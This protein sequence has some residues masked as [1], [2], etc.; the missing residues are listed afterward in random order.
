MIG[1]LVSKLKQDIIGTVVEN[2]CTN[3][4]TPDKQAF[5]GEFRK[6]YNDVI[7]GDRDTVFGMKVDARKM[8]EEFKKLCKYKKGGDGVKIFFE[9]GSSILV[10]LSGTED[11]ARVY[12]EIYSKSPNEAE[13]IKAAIEDGV[14]AIAGKNQATAL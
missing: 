1:K 4:A 8:E 6:I 5:I 10:R 11:K 12:K 3:Y 7:N 2:S 9:N 13:Q 14:R